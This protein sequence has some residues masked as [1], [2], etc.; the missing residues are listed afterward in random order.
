[1]QDPARDGRARHAA[2]KRGRGAQRG[3]P[4]RP[5]RIPASTAGALYLVARI[6]PA[7]RASED[8]ALD[9][10]LDLDPVVTALGRPA[11]F[12]D[13]P[14]LA[15][16]QLLAALRRAGTEHIYADTADPEELAA[17]L[18]HGG[19]GVPVEIDGNTANQPLVEKVIDRVL[20]ADDPRVWAR[21]VRGRTGDLGREGLLALLYAIA[22]GRIGNAITQRFASGRLW[23]GSLQLHMS[24]VHDPELARRVGRLL[25]DMVPGA[26]VKVPFAP[27]APE[28]LLVGPP[29]PCVYCSTSSSCPPIR[30]SRDPGASMSWCRWIA[31]RTSMQRGASAEP[32]PPSWRNVIPTS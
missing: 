2:R 24:L 32:S 9:A 21:A 25:R 17:L 15:S 28:T 27:H 23:E 8:S 11:R 5:P 31:A 4:G 16:T 20:D 6:P 1:L 29:S 19:D 26:L 12:P 30:S 18:E 10:S 3:V 7:P 22:C 14:R 13:Q